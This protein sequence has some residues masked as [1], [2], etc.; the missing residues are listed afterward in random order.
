MP[1]YYYCCDTIGMCDCL[2]VFFSSNT[3]YCRFYE[4]LCH[5]FN[6][7]FH[8]C[9]AYCY[10]HPSKRIVA[11]PVGYS[12]STIFHRFYPNCFNYVTN[13]IWAVNFFNQFKIKILKI[14]SNLFVYVHLNVSE[15]VSNIAFKLTINF[16]KCFELKICRVWI[17]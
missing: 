8:I 3:L 16:N 1:F 15:S 17:L 6:T 5:I 9:I 13:L 11:E 7:L 10:I 14:Y 4:S 12:K 2:C